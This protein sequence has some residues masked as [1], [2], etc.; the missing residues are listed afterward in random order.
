MATGHCTLGRRVYVDSGHR[1]SLYIRA[2]SLAMK[3]F[4]GVGFWL[5]PHDTGPVLAA[6]GRMT[7]ELLMLT[8]V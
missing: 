1:C 2:Y 3:T 8:G 5:L 6:L 4:L 7:L